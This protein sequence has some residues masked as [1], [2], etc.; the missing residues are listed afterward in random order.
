MLPC[1]LSLPAFLWR[2]SLSLSFSSLCLP[3]C[4]SSLWSLAVESR[5]LGLSCP[6]VAG[7]WVGSVES[8]REMGWDSPYDHDSGREAS[9]ASETLSHMRLCLAHNTKLGKAGVTCVA[10]ADDKGKLL[11]RCPR[12]HGG[13]QTLL[14]DPQ[15]TLGHP[16]GDG[17]ETLGGSKGVSRSSPMLDLEPE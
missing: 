2:G 3:Q 15:G 11:Q 4:G 9:T 5:G 12:S 8:A 1:P 7:A 16:L 6:V 13:P 17:R 14:L 10:G